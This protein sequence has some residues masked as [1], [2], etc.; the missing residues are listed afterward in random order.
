MITLEQYEQIKEYNPVELVDW[1]S[2]NN[3]TLSDLQVIIRNEQEKREQIEKQNNNTQQQI[4]DALHT[5]ISLIKD[6]IEERK[7]IFTV[8][9][10][11]TKL[12]STFTE[13][14]ME[15]TCQ[16]V[17]CTIMAKGVYEEESPS[18]ISL[19]WYVE[20]EFS[21]DP[22]FYVYCAFDIKDAGS[23][24]TK[25]IIEGLFNDFQAV[26]ESLAK[27]RGVI[28]ARVSTFENLNFTDWHAV[29]DLYVLP[30]YT[31]SGLGYDS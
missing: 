2:R 24:S 26:C 18:H 8:V 10:D 4:S 9:D 23:S 21:D 25:S 1:L 19:Y 11:K 15:L 28:T 29:T 3:Y 27:I 5:V 31:A 17:S 30:R 7:Q 13:Q 12:Y 22:T 14:V 6:C 20:R 16:G